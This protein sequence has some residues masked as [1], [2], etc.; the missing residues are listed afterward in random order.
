MKLLNLAARGDC[1]FLGTHVML[2][3]TMMGVSWGG[4]MDLFG[5]SMVF[6]EVDID[7]KEASSSVGV[8]L[9]LQ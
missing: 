1:V 2:D 9:D 6:P 5:V 3:L 4:L 8:S 7:L